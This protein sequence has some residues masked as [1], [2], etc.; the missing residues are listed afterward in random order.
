M[1]QQIKFVFVMAM[2]AMIISCSSEPR[3]ETFS[4]ERAQGALDF[5]AEQYRL[6][7]ASTPEDQ[8]PRTFQGDTMVFS[9]IYWWTSGFYPGSLW[10]LYEHTGDE[11]FRNEAHTR[12]MRIEPIQFRTDDHDVGFQLFCSFGNGYRLTENEAYVPI[13]ANGARSLATRF[14]PAVGSLKSWDFGR[15][16]WDFPV[17]ID[18]MMNLELLFWVADYVGE[19]NLHDLSVE[20]AYTSL[21]NHYREDFS[22]YHVVDFDSETG[23]VI[24]R[25]THQGLAD[26]SAWAR[27]QAWGLYGFVMSYRKTQNSDFLDHAVAIAEFLLNH[28]NMPEDHVPFW[29]FDDPAIPDT[30]RDASSASIMAS[31]L[32]ELSTMVEG[33]QAEKYFGAAELMLSSLS[34]EPYLAGLGENGNFILKHSVGNLNRM[35]EVDVPLTYADYYFIEALLRYIRLKS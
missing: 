29:D 11:F 12:T 4:V 19:Q 1:K 18:N 27:G 25:M 14:N 9:G 23:E 13:L 31:A 28:P 3:Q 15:D 5:A 17:I 10:Y 35:S 7:V 32:L 26:E 2:A 16:R 30:Y 6:K 24:K 20:H 8:E 34:Q 22:S 21:I 33:S